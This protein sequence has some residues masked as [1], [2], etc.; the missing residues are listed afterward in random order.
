MWVVDSVLHHGEATSCFW[1][2]KHMQ[3]NGCYKSR[4]DSDKISLLKQLEIVI[5]EHFVYDK[6]KNKY[7]KARDHYRTEINVSLLFLCHLLRLKVII[8]Q[9]FTILIFTLVMLL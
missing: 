5:S 4:N 1:L 3:Q 7:L 9:F 2:N 8:F 6:A